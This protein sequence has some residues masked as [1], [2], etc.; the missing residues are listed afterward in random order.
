MS[1]SEIFLSKWKT[2]ETIVRI[3][4]LEIFLLTLPS[5]KNNKI[6][7]AFNPIPLKEI[8]LWI[9]IVF[10]VQKSKNLWKILPK[11]AKNLLKIKGN[12]RAIC[13]ETCW[14]ILRAMEL[15][16][17][18]EEEGIV[19]LLMSS[20]LWKPARVSTFRPVR[21]REEVLEEVTAIIACLISSSLIK[22]ITIY[23]S[24]LHPEVNKIK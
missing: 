23:L 10:W 19:R 24:K 15:M 1:L 12:P 11:M 18:I 2:L 13:S 7:Y 8:P 21:A 20:R 6:L 4:P 22:S 9:M 3:K 5:I 17:L 14:K 16:L